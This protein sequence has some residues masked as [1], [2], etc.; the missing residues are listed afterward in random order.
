MTSRMIRFL[1]AA[2]VAALLLV[3][4]SRTQP[5]AARPNIVFI[6]IDDMGY[7]GPSSFGN[8]HVETPHIDSLARDGMKFTAAY[9]QPQCSPTRATLLT[10][11]HTARTNMWHV[12]G[13]YGY[14][15]AAMREPEY[16]R[17]L[18]RD[19][20]TFAQRLQEAG[21]ATGIFG[22][23]HM[24]I[25]EDTANGGLA[26]AAAR[27]YGFDV[28]DSVRANDTDD[29]GVRGLTD[30]ALEFIGARR[31]G[32]FFCFLSHYTVHTAVVAPQEIIDEY[33][34][35]GYPP[36]GPDQNEGQYNA[37]YLAMIKHLDNETGRL[38]AFLD[39][40]GLRDDTVVVFLSDNGGVLRC[41]DNR[42]F[43]LGKGTLYEGGVRVP[44]IVRWPG[45]V[46]PGSECGAPVHAVDFYPT[47]AEIAGAT[48]PPA[49]DHPLDGRSFLPLLRGETQ[50]ARTVYWHAPLYDIRWGAT[51]GGAIRDGDYKLIEF[52]GDYL[53]VEGGNRYVVG[54][55]VELYSLAEDIGET[56]N[57]AESMPEKRD[58]LLEKLRAWR[59]S[60]GA[61]MPEKNPAYDP[62]RA[63]EE[64]RDIRQ[65]R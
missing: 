28:A 2:A 44:M 57:L 15:W 25:N 40:E 18:P 37:T 58:E 13:N 54:P 60:L 7:T 26:P 17:N 45:V 27:H 3:S 1:A 59:E 22:K 39:A 41:F 61:R 8:Q 4:C 50:E 56:R 29:K 63:L 21:Y 47:F 35:K 55:R 20:P 52:F 10:G 34:A 19:L 16:A 42:P 31:G 43:R 32:P 53:D 11:Q 51:P 38:L 24:N 49:A 30:M 64:T 65:Y 12:V 23:W 9:V 36:A 6:L 5:P 62:A 46:A 14:P 33:L 48:L